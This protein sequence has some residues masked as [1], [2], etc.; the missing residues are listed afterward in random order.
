MCFPIFYKG[1]FGTKKTITL[2]YK[3]SQSRHQ[4][5]FKTPNAILYIIQVPTLQHMHTDLKTKQNKTKQNALKQQLA[6]CKSLLKH[7]GAP[8]QAMYKSYQYSPYSYS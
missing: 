7:P 4:E 8:F 3:Q 6:A 1:V 2:F 5:K